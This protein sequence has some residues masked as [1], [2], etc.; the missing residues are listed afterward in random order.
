V[1]G[2]R[3]NLHSF[4]IA[5]AANSY[6][7]FSGVLASLIFASV[8]LVM[9]RND[10]HGITKPIRELMTSFILLATTTIVYVEVSGL[11]PRT[12]GAIEFLLP[13]IYAAEFLFAVGALEGLL[14][15]RSL[16][17]LLWPTKASDPKPN[18]GSDIPGAENPSTDEHVSSN[19]SDIPGAENPS[20]DEHVSSNGSDIPGAENPST[21]EHESSN[22]SDPADKT[23][24][25]EAI[26]QVFNVLLIAFT[27]LT[28]LLLLLSLPEIFGTSMPRGAVFLALCVG[29]P[30]VV[31][32]LYELHKKSNTTSSGNRPSGKHATVRLAIRNWAS[33]GLSLI[34]G[35]LAICTLPNAPLS[36]VFNFTNRLPLYYEMGV[37]LLFGIWL[38]V[39]LINRN[40]AS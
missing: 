28:L 30:V 14:G 29:I 17:L 15:L 11:Q 36:S 31:A 37:Q 4:N 2:L 9:N 16:V 19:G 13:A 40:Y 39:K 26:A 5:F 20:T 21:D 27:I 32:L 6:A 23:S 25:A 22:G 10:I 24:E 12:V 34:F 35:I 7:A 33:L 8:I 18:K 38:A 3:N 1:P